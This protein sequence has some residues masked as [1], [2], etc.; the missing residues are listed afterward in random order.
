[1]EDC[2]V[3]LLPTEPKDSLRCRFTFE[4]ATLQRADVFQ[5]ADHA[6][7]SSALAHIY[8]LMKLNAVHS[9]TFLVAFS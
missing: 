1:M 5:N 2:Q 9:N 7:H 8:I 6:R 4:S 3:E